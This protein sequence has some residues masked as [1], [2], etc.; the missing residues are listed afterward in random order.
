MASVARYCCCGGAAPCGDCGVGPGESGSTPSDVTVANIT[1]TADCTALNGTEA[2]SRFA[3]DP[4]ADID[5]CYW[6]WDL[7][8]GSGSFSIIHFNTGQT[9]NSGGCQLTPGDGEWVAQIQNF[10]T[11]DVWNEITT[12]FSCDSAT[13]KVSGTHAFGGP[14][15]T[16]DCGGNP[17]A[18]VPA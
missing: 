16:V 12:G 7:D 4:G 6:E 13:G 8:G 18:T 17:T 10:V 9:I 5:G 11:G 14:C 1:G 3:R 2:F 15:N